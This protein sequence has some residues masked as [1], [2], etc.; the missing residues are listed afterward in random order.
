TRMGRH[1]VLL[2]WGG[3]L[4]EYLMPRLLLRTY[5][6]T[7]LED[8]YQAAVARQIQYG[9]QK[10]LPWGVSE[11]AFN[12]LDG[13]LDYQYRSFGVPGLGL[14]RGL[15]Q[16]LVVA[17]YATALALAV[18]P[19]AAVANFRRLAAEGALDSHGWFEALDYTKERLLKGQRVQ[20]I[21]SHMAHHQGMTLVALANALLD[22]VMPRRFHAEPLVRSAEMLLQER[23]PLDGTLREPPEAEETTAPSVN[24][25]PRHLSRRLTT[26]ATPT[27]RTNL[28]SNGRYTV[29]VTNAGSG[30]STCD[31]LDV[32]RWREDRTRDHWGQFFY[33][34]E[35]RGGLTWSAG[36]QPLGR[37]PDHYEVGFYADKADIRRRDSGIETHLEI[38]VSPEKNVEVRQLTLTNNHLRPCELEVTSYAEVVL[39]PRSA[40]LAHPAFGNLFV[41]TEW[42]PASSALLCR[43]RPRSSEQKPVWAF[44]VLAL[45]GTPIGPPQYETDRMRFL[46]RN[47]TPANPQALDSYVQL[48]GAT[49]A[50]LDP[51]FSIRRRVR[52][53]PG[54]TAR[55]AFSTGVAEDREEALALADRY[56]DLHAAVRSFELAWARA[57]VEL[58]HLQVSAEE[59]HAYQR[60]ATQ[61]I[62]AGSAL[63]APA[64]VLAANRLGQSALWR[65]GISGDRPIVVVRIGETEQLELVRQLLLAHSYWRMKGLEADL[66]V[67]NE[68]PTSY[69]EELQQQLQNLAQASDAHLLLDKPGGVFLRKAALLS[70]EDRTVLL[71]S[72]RAVLSGERGTLTNQ[73]DALERAVVL[74]PALKTRRPPA[75]TTGEGAQSRRPAPTNL[76][77]WNGLGGFTADGRAYVVRLDSGRKHTPAPWI[78]VVANPACGFLIS[79][80]GSGYTWVGNSQANRLTPWN[81]DAV[82]DSPGEVVYLRDEATGEVWTPTPLPI[83]SVAPTTIRHGQGYTSFEQMSHGLAQELLLFVPREDP[84]KVMRLRVRNAGNQP[85]RLSATFY[86]E[87]VLGGVRDLTHMHVQT[88]NDP[89][90]RAL[91]ARNVFNPSFP[92]AVAFADVN[93]PTRTVTA[94]RTEFL[95]RNGRLSSPAALGRQGLSGRVGAGLDPCAALQVKWE[96]RPGEEKE[97]VFLLGQAGTAGEVRTLIRRYREPRRVQTALTEVKDFW[98]RTLTTVQVRTPDAGMDLLLNRWLLYQVLSC[99]MWARSAFYQSGGAYGFRDQL[100]DVMALVY[101]APQEARAQIVRASGRQFVEGDV[102]HWWHPPEGRGVRTHFSDDLLWLPFVVCHYVAVTGDATVLQE[103]VPF[104]RAPLVDP[105]KEDQYGLPEVTGET[106]P[107]Y[108]HCRSALDMGFTQGSHGLPLM[109]CGDWNDGMNRV[110]AGGKCESVWVAWFLIDILKQVAKLADAYGDPERAARCVEQAEQL[111]AAIE[112]EAWDGRWYRRAYFDDGTPLGSAE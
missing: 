21:R 53:E 47:R 112:K 2:S 72:A 25:R 100:Q 5:P 49:G 96:L 31:G 83:P 73:L 20:V 6:G 24:E 43:R 14:K 48:S 97:I 70:E 91:L 87:W 110:G 26:A 62:Y 81:N 79:E 17:P 7:L 89:E 111:R 37:T 68:H 56:H 77:F 22:D 45:D 35:L 27:P 109:G 15:G 88:E 75:S 44:H 4:F 29:M 30:F 74:P 54:G 11:S 51:I 42:L 85:R 39:N 63:R 38:T 61:L 1:T 34:R 40:D 105:T 60:L 3:T 9:R 80:S 93:V 103:Y 64:G 18:D 28:L 65:H 67:L 76:A 46:G 16:D 19:D 71:A 95:G 33:I 66:V 8:A 57:Q 32:T 84:I 59:L 69:F 36:W 82:S 86:A 98:E 10:K 78:N 55:L 107:V 50:V 23:P 106:A 58:R 41:E 13:A 90:T 92:A 108:E 12:F 101:A 52:L 102:Q 99:R 104:L 94:D